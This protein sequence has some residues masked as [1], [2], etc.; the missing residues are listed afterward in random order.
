ML[1]LA[2]ADSFHAFCI[3]LLFF[4]IIL[5]IIRVERDCEIKLE[6]EILHLKSE[7]LA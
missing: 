7:M 2:L 6:N 1:F 3:R 5:K 4:N